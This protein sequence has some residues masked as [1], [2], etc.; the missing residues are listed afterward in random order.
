L[1]N[2]KGIGDSKYRAIKDYFTVDWA[3]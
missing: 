3:D 2:I 1:K